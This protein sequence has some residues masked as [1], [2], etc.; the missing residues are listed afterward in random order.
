MA[1]TP[2]LPLVDRLVPGGLREFL[3]TSRASG[4]S[5]Q[6]IAI[7]LAGEHDIR[8]TDTT[9]RKW[10]IELDITDAIPSPAELHS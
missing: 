5:Y 1:S 2:L 7:R 9:V 6:T 3:T 10:C 4:D 8:I